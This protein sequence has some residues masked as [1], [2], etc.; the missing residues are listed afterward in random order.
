MKTFNLLL[1]YKVGWA[2]QT[3]HAPRAAEV[4]MRL[5]LHQLLRDAQMSCR[6]AGGGQTGKRMCR[7]SS[8]SGHKPHYP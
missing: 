1:K 6:R 8:H 2:G 5:L 7:G 4:R 3:F